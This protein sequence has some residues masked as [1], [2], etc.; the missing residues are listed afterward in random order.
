MENL[1]PIQVGPNDSTQAIFLRK[2]MNYSS[3]QRESHFHYEICRPPS[4]DSLECDH[5][6]VREICQPR[7]TEFAGLVQ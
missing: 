1:W 3:I 7:I 2:K 5:C 4:R 6:K